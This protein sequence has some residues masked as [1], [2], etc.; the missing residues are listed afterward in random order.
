MLFL[1]TRFFSI[2]LSI[3]LI[4]S[5]QIRSRDLICFNLSPIPCQSHKY[6]GIQC[7]GYYV[8]KFNVKIFYSYCIVSYLNTSF[9]LNVRYL[10]RVEMKKGHILVVDDNKNV[11][12]AL[13][14][15]LQSRF[16]GVTLLSSPNTLLSTIRRSPLM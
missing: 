1:N 13:K 11:L 12:S 14:I 16:G 5:V 4:C 9:A 7:F 3:V 15:L 2:I 6:V 10:I 8:A